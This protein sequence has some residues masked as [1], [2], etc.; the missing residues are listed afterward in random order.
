MD[1]GQ[2]IHTEWTLTF[3]GPVVILS[4]TSS[5]PVTLAVRSTLHVHDFTFHTAI[6]SLQSTNLLAFIAEIFR[7]IF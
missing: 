3:S 2:R 5:N 6:I 7:I 1:I 4:N